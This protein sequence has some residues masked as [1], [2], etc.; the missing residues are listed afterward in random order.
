MRPLLWKKPPVGWVKV[1]YDASLNLALFRVGLGVAIRDHDG[2]LIAGKSL[3]IE[4]AVDLGAV[5]AMAF[6]HGV[7]LCRSLDFQKLILEGDAKVVIDALLSKHVN[8]SPFGH[9]IDE[10]QGS[11]HAFPHW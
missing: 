2:C 7:S 1:I 3:S 5:E 8:M 6:I 11:L 10:L 9:I 4:D